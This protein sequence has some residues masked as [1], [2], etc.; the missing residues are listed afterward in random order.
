[1]PLAYGG[2]IR[3]IKDV[4]KILYLGFEKV[5]LNTINHY[6][7]SFLNKCSEKFGSSTIVCS[8]DYKKSFFSGHKVY[9]N[10]GRVKTKFNPVE[11]AKT[12]EKNG[13]GELFCCSIDHEGTGKGYDIETIRLVANNVSIPIIASGGASELEDISK[14]FNETQV[15]AAAA[16][17]LFIYYGIH[18]AVLIN[19]PDFEELKDTISY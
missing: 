4:E 10:N 9:V 3:D 19:Y 15:S 16:G 1:M 12:L 5:I 6:D 13:A 11:Y 17:N 7:I 2:G 18:K 8:I 14:I